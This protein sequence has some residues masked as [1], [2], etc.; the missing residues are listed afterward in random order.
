MDFVLDYNSPHALIRGRTSG[1][2]HWRQASRQ[3]PR[4]MSHIHHHRVQAVTSPSPGDLTP[5]DPGIVWYLSP[6]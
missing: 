6:I 3:E 2:Q 5:S 1:T 4:Q